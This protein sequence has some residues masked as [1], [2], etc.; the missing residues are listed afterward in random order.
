MSWPALSARRPAAW[1]TVPSAIGSVNG[2]PSSITSAPALGSTLVSATDV[3]KSGSPAM[4]NVTSAARP[5]CLSAA[6]RVSMRVM[7]LLDRSRFAFLV[8]QRP[9]ADMHRADHRQHDHAGELHPLLLFDHWAGRQQPHF[10][11]IHRVE[12]AEDNQSPP[13]Q[14]LPADHS[15]LPRCSATVARSLSP[16]P[17]RLTAIRWSFGFFGARSRTRAIACA[18]SCRRLSAVSRDT[19]RNPRV[20]A[21]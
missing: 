21:T 8:A 7:R 10:Q 13:D 3:S 18:G 20:S 1:I 12:P 17:D 4:V 9:E 2:I 5:S 16:R 15:L 11:K 6:K 19:H 14:L